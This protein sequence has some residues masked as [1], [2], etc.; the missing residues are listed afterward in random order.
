[1]TTTASNWGQE[2]AAAMDGAGGMTEVHERH[3][4]ATAPLRLCIGSVGPFME[5]VVSLAEQTEPTDE[6][7][8]DAVYH[9]PEPQMLGLPQRPGMWA[10]EVVLEN[11]TI[12]GA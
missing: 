9:R 7:E 1:M 10:R 3:D 4:R 2:H 8:P 6:V 12:P 11:T 5:Q